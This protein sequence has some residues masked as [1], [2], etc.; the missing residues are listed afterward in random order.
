MYVI[1]GGALILLLALAGVLYA[2]SAN[3]PGTTTHAGSTPTAAAGVQHGSLVNQIDLAHGGWSGGTAPS[4]DPAGSI[5]VDTSSGSMA[6]TITKD[7]GS[8]SGEFDGPRLKNYVSNLVFQPDKGSDLEF[9]WDLRNQQD[10]G[11]GNIFLSFDVANEVMTLWLAPIN[12]GSNQPL[13]SAIPVPGLQNGAKV[14]LWMVVNGDNIK[15]YLDSKK[16]ADV[17]ESTVTG[18]ASPNF[19][20]QGKNGAAIHLITIAYYTVS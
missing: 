20:I 6:L 12:G 2:I 9:D 19:Y 14:D 8:M 13:T 10:N 7:G 5:T 18:A 3:K 1:G 17:N 15:L 16:V 4:P 11:P